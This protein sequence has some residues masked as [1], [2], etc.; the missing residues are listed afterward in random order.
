MSWVFYFKNQTNGLGDQIEI[1]DDALKY[2]NGPYEQHHTRG[3]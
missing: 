2:L 3:S 1:L